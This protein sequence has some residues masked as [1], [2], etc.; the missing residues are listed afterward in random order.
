MTLSRLAPAFYVAP[1][2]VVGVPQLAGGTTLWNV[3]SASLSGGLMAGLYDVPF[4][5]AFQLNDVINSSDFTAL[6]DTYYIKRVSITVRCSTL[7]V[8]SQAG[9]V[10]LTNPTIY[11]YTDYDDNTLPSVNDVRERMGVR[12]KQLVPGRAVRIS[13][14]PRADIPVYSAAG[15]L[16]GAAVGRGKQWLD[17]G[18][19]NIPHYGI[20]GM[21]ASLDCRAVAAGTAGFQLTFETKYTFGLRD[22]K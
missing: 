17:T 7:A 16:S 2:S 1:G 18:V 13:C 20:K 22:V 6:F 12:S 19:A 15:A 3:G 4:S 11:W 5:K 9:T 8:G 10:M 14:V 21:I